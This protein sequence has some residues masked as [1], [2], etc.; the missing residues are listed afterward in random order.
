MGNHDSEFLHDGAARFDQAR[1][2]QIPYLAVERQG[3]VD[4]FAD[5]RKSIAQLI[6]ADRQM[7]SPCRIHGIGLADGVQQSRSPLQQWPVIAGEE[8]DGVSQQVDE[9]Q[10][11][12][13]SACFSRQRRQALTRKLVGDRPG[14]GKREVRR[15]P[16]LSGPVSLEPETVND[17]IGLVSG[18]KDALERGA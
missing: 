7:Q 2:T 6:S 16:Q 5:G 14:S 1:D 11:V 4:G 18:Q 3:M 8:T 13:G 12:L 15:N 17:C 10:S 9:I